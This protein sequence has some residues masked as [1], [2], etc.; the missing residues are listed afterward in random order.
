MILIRHD[1]S[2]NAFLDR[3]FFFS[4]RIVPGSSGNVFTAVLVTLAEVALGNRHLAMRTVTELDTGIATGK[5]RADQFFS[6]LDIFGN[7]KIGSLEVMIHRHSTRSTG[8]NN[9]TRSL[10]NV[11]LAGF[12]RRRSRHVHL[13]LM[14][15]GR[16]LLFGG[17]NFLSRGTRHVPSSGHGGHAFITENGTANTTGRIHGV[18]LLRRSRSRLLSQRVSVDSCGHEALAAFQFL[19]ALQIIEF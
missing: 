12:G 3:W 5:I 9:R 18:L 10:F 8:D 6:V 1:M 14:A 4:A 13:M 11:F 17:S 15:R 2:G 16:G 19:Q 7:D